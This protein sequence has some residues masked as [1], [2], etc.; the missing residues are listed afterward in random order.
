MNATPR[1]RLSLLVSGLLLAS[2]VRLWAQETDAPVPA[3]D[4]PAV[5]PETERV[6][7]DEVRRFVSVFRAVQQAY[8]DQVPDQ[9]LMQSA[10]RGLLTDLDP[11]SAY[12]DARAT[13]AMNE[14]ATGAY[15]GLGLEILQRPDR[16][17]VVIAPMDDTPAARAGIQPGDIIIELDGAPISADSVDAAVEAM[18][19]EPGTTIVLTVLREGESEPLKLS[20]TR[21]IIRVA[22]ARGEALDTDFAYIRIATFQADTASEV[23]R[24]LES[25]KAAGGGALKGLVL[26]LRRNPG[27]LLNAGIEV[28]DLFLERG[29]IVST[30]G[31]VPR[32]SA[33]YEA[34]RGDLLDGAPIVVLIDSGS[35]SA[36]EVVAGALRDHRRALIMGSTSF[37]KGSVQTVLPL[38]NGDSIKLTTARY[39]TPNGISIQ[40]T[41][42]V[43]DIELPENAELRV[44]AQT[45]P[46]LREADLPGHL[47]AE[48]AASDTGEAAAQTDYAVNEALNLL[49]GLAV[50]RERG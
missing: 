36:A 44:G 7:L 42:I 35:A 45:S 9:Q 3:E 13:Q 18:R 1:L 34:K 2:S 5:V 4:T 14:T 27:G 24:R 29:V 20:L 37:G 28:A 50:F 6:S 8:V 16:S 19:G 43:P 40:A 11:H 47:E 22:S 33:E 17:L 26:D 46:Q 48:S 21:E 25:L 30:R 49:R 23:Q 32:A 41:G 39:Y 15:G 12:L 10:I 31:R 38:D